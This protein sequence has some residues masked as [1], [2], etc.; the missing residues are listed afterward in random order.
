MVGCVPDSESTHEVEAELRAASWKFTWLTLISSRIGIGL[1]SDIAISKAKLAA[2][3]GLNRRFNAD[4]V[5]HRECQY[6]SGFLRCSGQVASSHIQECTSLR[7]MDEAICQQ[8]SDG[9]HP[10]V[11]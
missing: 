3:Y 9:A 6:V 5:D 8:F 11:R 2:P 7:V 1:T 10:T 4:R